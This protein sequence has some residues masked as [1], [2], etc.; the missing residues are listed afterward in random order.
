MKYL[1]TFLSLLIFVYY[2]YA[3][4]PEVI[5]SNEDNIVNLKST[6]FK[7]GNLVKKIECRVNFQENNN[8]FLI[9][10]S[11]YAYISWIKIVG[12]GIG[13]GGGSSIHKPCI[14]HLDFDRY[15]N[16]ETPFLITLSGNS[17]KSLNEKL[18]F[19]EGS[20]ANLHVTLKSIVYIKSGNSY[21]QHTC[22]ENIIF[23]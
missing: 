21:L 13:G 18:N 2:I 1:S 23:K 15:Y 8:N 4:G 19:I 22:Y 10:K 14:S 17:L 11:S 5:R 12:K 9:N 7:S 20:G 3:G 16:K 6:V